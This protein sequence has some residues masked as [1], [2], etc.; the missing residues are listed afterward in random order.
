MHFSA[1]IFSVLVVARLSACAA[2]PYRA[3]PSLEH[4]AASAVAAQFLLGL[5]AANQQANQQQMDLVNEW[6]ADAHRQSAQWQEDFQSRPPIPSPPPLS[7]GQ[8]RPPAPSVVQNWDEW[9]DQYP[10]SRPG[11]NERAERVLEGVMGRWDREQE[12]ANRRLQHER[13]MQERNR[14]HGIS[15]CSTIYHNPEAA[16]ECRRSLGG[17]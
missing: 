5:N 11:A 9:N 4:T 16:A 7:L 12:R 17:W 1:C 6:A 2:S 14:Q 13:M 15:A 3:A 10:T 8:Q